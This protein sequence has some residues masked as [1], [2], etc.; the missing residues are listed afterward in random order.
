MHEV[1]WAIK[2]EKY[3]QK[4]LL[5]I[6]QFNKIQCTVLW[7]VPSAGPGDSEKVRLGDDSRLG[8]KTGASNATSVLT[9][10]LMN[11]LYLKY[12]DVLSLR[13]PQDVIK[14]KTS[15]PNSVLKLAFDGTA[16]E[17]IVSCGLSECGNTQFGWNKQDPQHVTD[18][19]PQSPTV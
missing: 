5:V 17:E 8:D 13:S 16:V 9:V 15:T 1:T 7:A 18:D 2:K 12:Y 14:T 10:K 6:G 11:C 3:W 4:V 19:F